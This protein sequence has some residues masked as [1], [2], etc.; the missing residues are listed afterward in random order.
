MKSLGPAIYTGTPARAVMS[1]ALPWSSTTPSTTNDPNELL[2]RIERNT[3]STLQWTKY[4]VFAILL[5]IVV[6][7][8]L[9][10]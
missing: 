7:I 9:L 8:V 2:S 6:N 3:A 5:L 1:G 4:L 10:I